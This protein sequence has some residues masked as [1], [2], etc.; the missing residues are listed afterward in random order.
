MTFDT[1]EVPSVF[2]WA[3]SREKETSLK[4]R[5]GMRDRLPGHREWFR[6]T[7][8]VKAVLRS[9]PGNPAGL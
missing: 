8:N 4:R 3:G 1:A 2:W 5:L 9:V 6:L 7:R